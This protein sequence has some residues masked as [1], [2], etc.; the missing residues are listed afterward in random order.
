MRKFVDI[1]LISTLI[2]FS[3]FL[4]FWQLG[5]SVSGLT[6]LSSLT[7]L[8]F[9]YGLRRIGFDGKTSLVSAFLLAALPWHIQESR[10]SQLGVLT[11]AAFVLCLAIFAKSVKGRAKEFA[12]VCTGLAVLALIASVFIN[13][14]PTAK[15][16]VEQERS[17][18]ER[19]GIGIGT[20]V[21][22]NKFVESGRYYQQ[23]L[24]ENMDIGNYFFA[25]HPRERLGVREEQKFF[26]VMLPLVV[27]GVFS[28][29]R[30][31]R[32]VMGGLAA[33][34]IAIPV[35]MGD[36]AEVL[37]L[38]LSLPAVV[39]AA[40][41]LTWLYKGGRSVGKVTALALLMGLGAETAFFM[42]SYYR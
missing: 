26:M 41:G 2:I 8:L 21:F 34:S 20:R 4:R 23:L 24:F 33:L 17:Y 19:L 32:L 28:S 10:S 16:W 5:D 27:M 40:E 3:L 36:R 9:F 18:M 22:T 29:S 35:V 12:A 38:S 11:T 1:V 31:K 30:E 37:G 13:V 14:P 7:P 39:F 15:F 42:A 6:V 25:G